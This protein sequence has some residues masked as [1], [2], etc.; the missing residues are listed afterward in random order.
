VGLEQLLGDEQ[1]A[2]RDGDDGDREV[3]DEDAY[4]WEIVAQL[5]VSAELA[6]FHLAISV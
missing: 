1:V 6:V 3:G 4:A 5:A 2:H